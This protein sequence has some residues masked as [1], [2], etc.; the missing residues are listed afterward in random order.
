MDLYV[1]KVSTIGAFVSMY[2]CKYMLK[3]KS[4][5]RAQ[6]KEN[7]YVRGRKGSSMWLAIKGITE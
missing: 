6:T 7:T 1:H 3:M 4:N 5:K 2:K